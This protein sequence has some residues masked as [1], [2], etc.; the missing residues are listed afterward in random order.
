[1]YIKIENNI[2]TNW[3]DWAFPGSS[4]VDIDYEYFNENQDSFKVVEG[5][6]TDISNTD[7]YKSKKLEEERIKKLLENKQALENKESLTTSFGVVKVNTPIGRVDVMATGFLNLVSITKA[8]LPAGSFRTYTDGQETSSPEMTPEQVG[9][10]YLE[11]FNK[12]NTLDKTYKQYEAAINSASTQ[13]E[14]DSVILDY[15]LV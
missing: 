10:F 4:Y 7:E 2:L 3:A 8:N 1:M 11:I 6:L 14:L 12:L 15:S 13:S 5:V 9:A